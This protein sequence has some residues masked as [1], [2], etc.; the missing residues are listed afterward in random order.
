VTDGALLSAYGAQR[1]EAAFRE[2]VHRHA[3]LVYGVCRRVLTQ[4]TD[5]ED[6][7][8]ATFTFLALQAKSIDG[9]RPLAGWLH[10]V[11]YRVALKAR[12]RR[13]RRRHVETR[14]S[15]HMVAQDPPSTELQEIRSVLD[16]ELLALPARERE[17]ILLCD[18]EGKGHRNVAEELRIPAGSVSRRLAAVRDRLRERLSRRGI[19]LA[20]GTLAVVLAAEA[21][22]AVPPRLAA[23]AIQTAIAHS[24]G[25]TAASS[26]TELVVAAQRDLAM[27][28]FKVAAIVAALAS[29]TLFAVTALGVAGIIGYRTFLA[30]NRTTQVAPSAEAEPAK[31]GLHLV[32][33]A[34]RTETTLRDGKVTPITLRLHFDNQTDRPLKIKLSRVLPNTWEKRFEIKVIG[35]DESSALVEEK[36][37]AADEGSMA[38]FP[39]VNPGDRMFVAQC[40]LP[41]TLTGPDNKVRAYSFSR[42]GRY[43]VVVRYANNEV[44]ASPMAARTWTGTVESN[45]III[46]VR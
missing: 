41:G 39:V 37:R 21:R 9:N 2:L 33:E 7:F 4:E 3:H 23:L 46:T 12:A 10:A 11:A 20:S 40:D 15:P 35:Q 34:D 27:A 29:V 45:E 16:E 19:S 14:E 43:R 31:P 17:L 42:P 6:A 38:F 18:V 26:I 1:D 24:A 44:D 25:T 32:L 8:Q 13:E 36:G 22:A 5:A 28:R 30:S